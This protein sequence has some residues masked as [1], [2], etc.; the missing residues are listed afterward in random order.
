MKKKIFLI[1]AVMAV[2][3]CF[4]A[5]SVSA[6]EIDGIE[7][8]FNNNEATV[9]KANL[10]VVD[11]PETVTDGETTYTVT[12][13]ASKAFKDNSTITSVTIPSSVVSVGN[14]AF[15]S[16]KALTTVVFEGANTTMGT[17]LFFFC[18]ANLTSVTLPTNLVTIPSNTFFGCTSSSFRI[19][20]ADSLTKLTT[21]GASAFQDTNN[22]T[23]T[24]PD[25]V[26]TIEKSA[27]QSACSKSGS[28][29][30]NPTSKLVTIGESAFHDCKRLPSIYIPSTV[31]SIGPKA[32]LSCN[33]LSEVANFEN[34]QITTIE[35]GTFQ[36]VWNIR[37]LKIPKTVTTIGSAF[38]DNNNLTLVYIPKSVTSIANTFTGGKP[39]NAVFIYTGSDASVLS[40]C[41]KIAGAKEISA[42]EYDEDASYSGLNLVVGYSHCLA[43][44]NGNHAATEIKSIDF[45]SYEAP[46]TIHSGC[47]ECG[48]EVPDKVI[49]ALFTC[50]GY[51]IPDGERTGIAVTYSINTKGIEEYET[52]TNNTVEYGVFAVSKAKLG[53]NEIFGED[54][55]KANG[56]INTDLTSYK[57][58]SVA[59]KITGF[60]GY[61]S[62]EFALGVYVKSS[63]K[64][65]YLQKGEIAT[66]DKYSF[67]SYNA[68]IDGI[69]KQNEVA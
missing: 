14:E 8:S 15:R 34:C 1:I 10:T 44:N 36:Y 16:C 66:G 27:F 64:Y 58:G 37:T 54:G 2:L 48:K 49:G 41:S 11:I 51:S 47:S 45:T 13:I 31:T 52:L 20:N 62:K 35:D 43:Y 28:I 12:A 18:G 25:S 69:N 65:S 67:T 63:G 19:T 5:I 40:T 21:I 61:E 6:V 42:S 55:A 68:I 60:D 17:H 46:I 26:T 53:E 3:T 39:T 56:V 29:T 24:I 32:F 23:F 50:V 4:F 7:Y 30:I 22:L 9:T 38:A 33:V 59:L 57:F